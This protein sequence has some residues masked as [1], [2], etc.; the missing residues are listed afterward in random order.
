MG[1]GLREALSLRSKLVR[2]LKRKAMKR[3]KPENRSKAITENCRNSRGSD[4]AFPS[5]RRF[6]GIQIDQI[7]I[8]QTVKTRFPVSISTNRPSFE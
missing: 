7:F 3:Q 1:T 6:L 2:G 4:R 5:S 8:R